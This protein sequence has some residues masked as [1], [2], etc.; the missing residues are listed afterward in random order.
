MDC[1]RG[2]PENGTTSQIRTSNQQCFIGAL[3]P[4][5]LVQGEDFLA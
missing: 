5:E 4:N 1:L 3:A 2:P